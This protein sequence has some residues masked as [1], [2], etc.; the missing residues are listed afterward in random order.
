MTIDIHPIFAI[1]LGDARH[2]SPAGL[3][4]SLKALV[5]QLESQGDSYRNVDAVVHQPEGLFESRFEFF[6][7][8]EDCVAQLR[9]WCWKALS[10][11]IAQV[12]PSVAG[13]QGGL[14]INSQTWFHVTRTGGYFGFHNHPMAS[15][16]GVYC[17]DDGD[18]DPGTANNGCLVFPPPLAGGNAFIDVTNSALNAPF[19]QGNYVIPLR[20]GQLVVFPSWMGHYVTPFRGSAERITVAFNAWF[21]HDAAA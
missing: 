10:E 5:L 8:G 3:N 9:A 15:W 18:P 19:A 4:A 14:R 12:C 1:P 17:V 16:S 21:R 7:R 11:F 6:S 13:L 2:P 20:P